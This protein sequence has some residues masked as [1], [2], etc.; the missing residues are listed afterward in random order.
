MF[1]TRDE[2]A[3]EY[4]NE[5]ITAFEKIINDR[6]SNIF[7]EL[8]RLSKGEQMLLNILFC[9]KAP[10]TPTEISS[11]MKATKGRV[12]AILNS[13]EKKGQI[14]RTVLS[15][16]RRNVLVSITKAGKKYA[17]A[18]MEKEF[19]RMKK[20]FELMGETDTKDF[21][22]LCQKMTA[23]LIELEKSHD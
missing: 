21:V 17:T 16:N 15:S 10:M 1:Y 7:E 2:S 4:I 19:R 23:I 13:L 3:P 14:E 11:V 12:S 6:S 22:R 8:N 9:N 5:A 18:E 20:I